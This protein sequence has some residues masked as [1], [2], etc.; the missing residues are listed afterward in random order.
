MHS[1]ICSEWR[2][3]VSLSV[4]NSHQLYWL[5]HVNNLIA[6]TKNKNVPLSYCRLGCG[7]RWAQGIVLDGVQRC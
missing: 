1:G 6:T 7:L 2:V 3:I 4:P 5:S